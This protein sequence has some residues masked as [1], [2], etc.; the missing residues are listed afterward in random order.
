MRRVLA[1]LSAVLLVVFVAGYAVADVLDRVPGVLTRAEPIPSGLLPMPAPAPQS[2]DPVGPAP[3]ASALDNTLSPLL[4][5]PA[6]GRDT[7][8]VVRDALTQQ[9]IWSQGA[10]EPRVLASLQKILA[11][12]LLSRLLPLDQPMHTVAVAGAGSGE[13]VLVAGGDTLLATGAGDPAAVVGR[14]GLGDLAA[15][16]A[17]AA[18]AGPLTVRLD[19]S[20]ARGPRI[21]PSWDP[22]DV[23]G[24]FTR[25]I[26]QIGLADL[27]PVDGVVPRV[28]TD[29]D[30]LAAFAEALRV[31]GREV[32]VPPRGSDL[33]PS[34]PVVPTK[35]VLGSVASA[36]YV[37]VIDL[38]VATSD[39]ALVENLVRQA[40]IIGKYEFPPSGETGG[41]VTQLLKDFG[42]P[43]DGVQLTD[44]SGLGPGQRAPLSAI[45]AVLGTAVGTEDLPLRRLVAQLPIAG[46]NGTLHDRFTGDDVTWAVG[47][48]R[49]KTGTLSG[50]SALAGTTVDAEGR[51]LTFAVVANRVPPNAG[52]KAAR[53]ALDRFVAALTACGCR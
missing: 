41:P 50:V 51:L 14:A 23:A 26:A 28:E 33:A 24:G 1:A 37:D 47:I 35:D 36:P 18:P 4:A 15:Q 30:T 10:D 25:G 43:T 45:D 49:A 19:T 27:R 2:P 52:T 53:A 7:G 44:A 6:L 20:Y 16:V 31:R 42:I 39:N 5:D 29:D 9:V 40:L 22:A 34:T 12:P 46:V 8:V 11:L 17:A 38:A 32:T 3:V 13:V 48:P 21:L